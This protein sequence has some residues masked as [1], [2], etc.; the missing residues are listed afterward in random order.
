[1]KL[2]FGKWI[3]K[4]GNF[5]KQIYAVILSSTVI[6]SSFLL[7]GC[8]KK[9]QISINNNEKIKNYAVSN[10]KDN[11]INLKLYFD[12]SSSNQKPEIAVEERLIHQDEM[13]GE[14]IMQELI[15]GPSI[16]S[17]LKPIFPNETKLLSF[18]IK[19]EIAYINLSS[20]ANISM[21]LAKEEAC[22]KSMVNS[23]TQITTIKKIK[24]MIE[25]KDVELFGG[26]YDV[27]KPFGLEDIQNILK[28]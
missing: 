22:L 9:D 8:E 26:N 11:N 27:S 15:K 2:E 23:L 6:I 16:E 21:S 28:K 24:I 7:G 17:K 18:S 14:I 20:Q 13:L 12:S 3:I 1:M 19:D 10:E 4:G 25:N 5:M